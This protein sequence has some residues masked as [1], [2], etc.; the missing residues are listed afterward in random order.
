ME[1]YHSIYVQIAGIVEGEIG[2]HCGALGIIEFSVFSI[3]R[4]PAAISSN[5]ETTLLYLLIHYP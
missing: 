5:C 1:L 3:M 2:R 4:P